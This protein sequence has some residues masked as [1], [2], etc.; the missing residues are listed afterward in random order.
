MATYSRLLLSGS[1]NGRNIPVAATATPGTTIHTAVSGTA[2]FDE[3][4]AWAANV[5]GAPVTL[6]VQW[7]GT[8]DP[9]D[10]L[11]KSYTIPAYS[12]PVPIVTGQVLNN[13]LL[14]R[15]F[16]SVASA[17]NISGFVNR[18]S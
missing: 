10:H 4:Y 8:T 2:S 12:P 3:V 1:T 6:T 11:V 16:C 7:G 9:G 14:F 13:G 17:I 15:A 18:I 5:T